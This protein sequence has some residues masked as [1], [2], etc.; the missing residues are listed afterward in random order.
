MLVS[1]TV[2]VLFYAAFATFAAGLTGCS[3]AVATDPMKTGSEGQAL[4]H[5]DSDVPPLP[6]PALAVPAGNELAFHLDAVGVQIYSCN[7]TAT[8]FGWVFVAPE[9]TLYREGHAVGKHYAGPTW[10]YK[11]GS[12]VIGAKLAA[13]TPDPASIPWL[14]LGAVSHTGAGKMADVTYVQRLETAGGIAPAT[15]CDATTVGAGAR[16]PY[17]ATYYFSKADDGS[18]HGDE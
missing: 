16:V 15:G 8:G 9:A 11:D 5:H 1:K 12:K 13:A 6:S 7:A 18:E 3:G 10:E 14:L 4:A 17:T 2:T